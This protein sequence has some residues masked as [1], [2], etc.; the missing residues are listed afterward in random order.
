MRMRTTL[1]LNITPVSWTSFVVFLSSS[2]QMRVQCVRDTA[3]T[4]SSGLSVMSLAGIFRLHV[5]STKLSRRQGQ[6]CS[7][8]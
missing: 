5:I 8:K 7:R 4:N 3:M 1:V 2:L 6:C